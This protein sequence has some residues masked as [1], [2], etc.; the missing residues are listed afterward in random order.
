MPLAVVTGPPHIV[1]WNHDHFDG[2]G[3]A[4]TISEDEEVHEVMNP[5]AAANVDP[6][7]HVAEDHPVLNQAPGQQGNLQT[8]AG[9]FDDHGDVEFAEDVMEAPTHAVEAPDAAFVGEMVEMADS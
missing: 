2:A 9:V 7:L 4:G 8:T 3:G 5:G 1:D 6:N